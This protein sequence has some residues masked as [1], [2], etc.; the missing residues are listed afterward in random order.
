MIFKTYNPSKEVAHII[1]CYWIIEDNDMVSLPKKII[2]DGYPEII[3]HYKEPYLISVKG[4]WQ[5]QDMNL[6]AGQCTKYFYLKNTGKS[7]MAGIKFKPA[8]LTHLYGV[9]MHLLKDKVVPLHE[10]LEH[11][12]HQVK[13][14]IDMFEDHKKMISNIDDYF[15]GLCSSKKITPAAIDN[16][17]DLI[18]SKKGI[19]TV[20]EISD[21]ACLG[22]RQLLNLFNRYV[23]L[24]PKLFARIIRLN[25]I[26][27]LV[28]NNTSSWSSLAYEA[29][30]FDQAHFIKD[31][32]KFTGDSPSRYAFDEQTMANFFLKRS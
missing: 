7:G 26:F 10:V 27:S 8:A 15:K 20:S 12:Y 30:F 23:G 5:L 14:C 24:S 19:V 32:Q 2:P 25:Y 28:K 18:I 31:F 11:V 3:F 9:S 22:E 13:H 1:E 17:V 16:A 4:E 29:A 21:K 6:F